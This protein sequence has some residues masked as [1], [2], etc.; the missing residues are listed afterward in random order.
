MFR[1]SL[2]QD[3]AFIHILSALNV[4]AEEDREVDQRERLLSDVVY[5][6]RTRQHRFDSEKGSCGSTNVSSKTSICGQPFEGSENTLQQDIN[7]AI[8]EKLIKRISELK[9][10]R[11]SRQKPYKGPKSVQERG[12]SATESQLEEFLKNRAANLSIDGK[13]C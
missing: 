2:T 12:S 6:T 8:K 7:E 11:E 3:P 5:P 9:T 10:H 1:Q 13:E 4:S